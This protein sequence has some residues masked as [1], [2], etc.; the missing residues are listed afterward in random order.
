MAVVL[1]TVGVV[2]ATLASTS[3]E[4]KVIVIYLMT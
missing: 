4:K 2:W 1:V 3:A